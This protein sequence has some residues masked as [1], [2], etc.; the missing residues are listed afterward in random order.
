[1]ENACSRTEQVLTSLKGVIKAQ[2][3]DAPQR[4]AALNLEHEAEEK[5]LMGLCKGV[6]V[7][8]REALSKKNVFACLTDDTLVWP[9]CSY[10]KLYCGEELIG[11]DIYD[12]AELK[13]RKEKGDIVAGNLVFYKDKM[14]K[15]K[16]KPSEMR[17]H[18]MPMEITE[19]CAC[20]AV[21]ASPSPPADNYLKGLLG[22]DLSD[23]RLGTIVVGVD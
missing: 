17:V 14:G 16:E 21:V 20:G 5:V 4:E 9:Q 2:R 10:I 1:M 6:N 7:G 19:L 8:L 22:A 11:K 3:L 15:L 13:R 23:K 18:M 12:E